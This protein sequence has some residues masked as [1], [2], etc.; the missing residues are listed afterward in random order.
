MPQRAVASRLVGDLD[1]PVGRRLPGERRGQR[2]ADAL[3]GIAGAA[4]HRVEIEEAVEL[5]RI[6]QQLHRHARRAQAD[7]VLET[8]VA[9]R[10]EARRQHQR[11]RQA[12]QV[13]GAQRGVARVGE[14]EGVRRL[15]EQGFDDADGFGTQEIIAIHVFRVGR[16]GLGIRQLGGGIDQHL[17]LQRG[18]ATAPVFLRHRRRQVAARGIA[19]DRQARGVDAQF[20]TVLLQ[21]QQR[22]ED[23]VMARRD[24]VLRCPPVLQ[25]DHDAAGLQ[26]DVAADRVGGIEFADDEAAAEAPE[27]SRQRL[28]GA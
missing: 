28:D 24:E 26:G 17:H 2:L 12:A 7:G 21:P 11:R 20:A 1:G 10:V 25:R 15:A 22:G 13:R 6:V 3:Q 27:E 18:A 14:V 5:P 8:L 19:A 23:V 9:D 4:Q 16:Q